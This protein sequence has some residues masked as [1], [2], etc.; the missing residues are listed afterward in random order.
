MSNQYTQS[1]N[2]KEIE[3]FQSKL[4]HIMSEIDHVTQDIIDTLYTDMKT[5]LIH[6]AKVTDM[7]KQY[8]LNS[9]YHNKRTRRHGKK[10]WFNDECEILRKK[11]LLIKNSLRYVNTSD[12]LYQSFY[13]HVK[14]YKKL[15]SKTKRTHTMQFQRKIRNLKTQNPREFWNILKSETNYKSTEIDCATFTEF[16]EHFRELNNDLIFTGIV[17]TSGDTSTS[18]INDAINQPFTIDEI[19]SSIKKLKNNKTSGVDN[20][21]N[22]FF[23]YAHT[24]CIQLTV[25]FF[26]IVLNTGCVPTDWCLGTIHPL[27]KNKGSVSDP[28]NYRGITLLSCTGKLFTTCLNHRLSSYVDDT[29]LGE[30]QAGFRKGY[31]TTDHVFVLHLIIELY[32]SVHKRVYCAFIDYR[33]AFDSINRPLLWQKLLSQDINGKLLNVIR[34]MYAK[35]KSCIQKYNMTSEYFRCNVGVRQGD[36]LSPLLFALFLNDFLQFICR[37]YTGLNISDTC[38][39]SLA[40]EHI[41]LLKVFALLYADDTIVLA[42]NEKELQLALDSVHEYCTLYN[43]TVNTSKIK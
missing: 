35:A 16:I 3:Q 23:K 18:T 31:S 40:D 19:K 15:V 39:P 20:V 32:K 22:E 14:Q 13:E 41:V 12:A 27:Y 8:T 5:I 21:V 2:V 42:E 9:S 28:D 29:I 34:N 33:K 38:Y 36:N 4:T 37:S 26:N 24:D 1:F 43:L 11:C 10:T 30:E 25:D 6:P 7:Y 17:H